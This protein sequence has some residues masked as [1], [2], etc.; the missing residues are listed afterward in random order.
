MNKMA[1]KAID[2]FYKCKVITKDNRSE[3]IKPTIITSRS[4]DSVAL[5]FGEPYPDT[6]YTL[7]MVDQR[8]R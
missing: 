5:D 2:Q 1:D 8:S 7:V 6:H 3:A 4:W